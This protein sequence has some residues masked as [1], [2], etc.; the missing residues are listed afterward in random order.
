MEKKIPWTIK[1]RPKKISDVVDQEQAKQRI[2]E[3]LKK[4]PNVEK[5]ALLLYGPP[6]VGKSSLVEAVANELGYELIELNA[7]DSRRRHTRSCLVSWARR[8]V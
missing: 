1:Y 3:W 4:W 7:S 5:R 8:C 6:G 2:L